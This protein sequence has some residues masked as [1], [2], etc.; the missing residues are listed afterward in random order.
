[1][2]PRGCLAAEFLDHFAEQSVEPV[3]SLQH[4]EMPNQATGR[5]R[6]VLPEWAQERLEFLLGRWP[7]RVL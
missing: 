5:G 1:V 4:E 6:E 3:G 7:P 2:L